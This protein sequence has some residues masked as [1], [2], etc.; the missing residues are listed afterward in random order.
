MAMSATGTA[1]EILNPHPIGLKSGKVLK[2]FE[3]IEN[4]KFGN[5]PRRM[6]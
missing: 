6:L 5:R 3:D 4:V 2:E 1:T